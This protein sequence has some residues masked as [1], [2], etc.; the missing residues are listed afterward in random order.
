MIK[1]KGESKVMAV[2]TSVAWM[3]VM[4]IA[5]MVLRA[6]IKCIGRA[7]IPA[8]VIAGVIGF[9]FMNTCGLSGTTN[10]EYN[11]VSG[12][13]YTF[14]F[15]N[16]GLN[17]AAHRE[18]KKKQKIKSLR[19]LRAR[20][21]DSMASGI[22][23]MG[24]FWAL[25]YSFQAILGFGVLLLIGGF[26]DMDPTYGLLLPFSFAQGPGQAIAYGAEMEISGWNDAIQVGI[27]FA[28][29]GFLCAYIFGV[30]FAKRGMKKGIACSKV[31]L[32][33]DIARGFF[34][35]ENQDSYGK[36]T[37]YSGAID[38]LTFHVAL[39]GVCWILGQQVGKLWGL[40]P[41]YF[42]QLFSGLLFFNGMLV[43]YVLRYILGKLGLTKYLDRGTQNRMTGIATDLMV[44]GA[45]MAIDMS[46]V[47]KWI[48]PIL[49]CCVLCALVTW[50]AIRYFGARFGGQND[51]ER[52]LGEWGTATGTNATGISLVRIVDPENETT[53]V[54]ELGP[55]NIVNVPAS[56]FV[57]PAILTFAAGELST[58]GLMF[59]LFGLMIGYLI[60]MAV[61]GCWGKK[62]FSMSKGEKYRDGKVY[63]RNGEKVDE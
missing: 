14:L 34:E 36:L 40:I 31:Q 20:M 26:F 10:A 38:T 50:A 19:D 3:G 2:M 16:M 15:I 25:A 21:G 56:Y 11:L 9:I 13:M 28:S 48:V 41:G 8:C 55:A 22:F 49:V 45:F 7:M 52:T 6:K 53:T 43:A 59:C 35:P 27:T 62:T 54:A 30:P 58:G 12:Q 4:L 5:A 23:G 32:S 44:T 61:I 24:S 1:R 39:V 57:M 42:G 29:A 46:I 17:L 37:T 60:F 18:S 63:M 47:G 33:D 51:F